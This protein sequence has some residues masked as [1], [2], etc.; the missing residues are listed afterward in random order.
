MDE[1]VLVVKIKPGEHPETSY[2]GTSLEDMQNAVDGYIEFV[3]IGNDCHILC[4]E[5]GKIRGLEP[6]RIYGNDV[7]VGV[8]YII[9]TDDE[10]D[11]I[12]LSDEEVKLYMNLFYEPVPKGLFDSTF[13]A[14]KHTDAFFI[15]EVNGNVEWVYFN[16]DGNHGRGQFVSNLFTF[17]D[18]LDSAEKHKDE[19]SFFDY[20]G[21][22]AK[23]T[24]ADNGTKE[25]IEYYVYFNSAVDLI[26]CSMRTMQALV[27][28][29]KQ[30]MNSDKTEVV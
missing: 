9:K 21:T 20:L 27:D 26:D 29:A 28:G 2:L 15:N 25:Y 17:N 22:V 14:S 30:N 24:L 7:I 3:D 18:V 11:L 19:N 23:Q 16:P 1:K 8:M 5:E 12:S 13:K 10:G 6:N 4:N